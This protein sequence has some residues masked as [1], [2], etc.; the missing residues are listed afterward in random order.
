MFKIEISFDNSFSRSHQSVYI[1]DEERA[2]NVY[3]KVKS[4]LGGEVNAPKNLEIKTAGGWCCL[5]MK[6]LSAVSIDDLDHLHDEYDLAEKQK[7]Y[8][9]N[10]NLFSKLKDKFGDLAKEYF[11]ILKSK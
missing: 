8:E 5:S 11:E 10:I 4:L 3:E 6:G 1:E 2:K 7:A 9:D